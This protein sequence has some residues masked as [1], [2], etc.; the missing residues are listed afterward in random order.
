SS[1]GHSW[2]Q[3]ALSWSSTG[4]Q[5]CSPCASLWSSAWGHSWFRGAHL[6]TWPAL[7]GE[8]WKS[9]RPQFK[10]NAWWCSWA[11]L[12]SLSGHPLKRTGFNQLTESRKCLAA[13]LLQGL[14]SEVGRKP[15]V[16]PNVTARG[17]GRCG[18]AAA[19]AGGLCRDPSED[20]RLADG[21]T[22]NRDESRSP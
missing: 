2:F 21:P 4:N 10:R 5:S 3:R 16:R 8:P 14:I 6:H 13:W 7:P 18:A 17:T 15:C 20:E 22:W 9:W 12:G 11:W 19:A 1:G